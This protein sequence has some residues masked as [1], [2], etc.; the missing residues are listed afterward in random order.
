MVA[1]GVASRHHEAVFWVLP[2]LGTLKPVRLKAGRDKK[3]TESP[4]GTNPEN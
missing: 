3:E 4:A 1:K 2:P